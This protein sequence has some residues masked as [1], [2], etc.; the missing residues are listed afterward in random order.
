MRSRHISFVGTAINPVWRPQPGSI[1]NDQIRIPPVAR[2][3]R[4]LVPSWFGAQW[5]IRV[6]YTKPRQRMWLQPKEVL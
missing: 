3:T 1:V 2:S 6:A 5:A 4:S